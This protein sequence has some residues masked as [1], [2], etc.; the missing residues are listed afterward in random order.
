M[1]QLE[2]S[3]ILKG[4]ARTLEA[5]LQRGETSLD[6]FNAATRRTQSTMKSARDSASVF[7]AGLKEQKRSIDSLRASLDPLYASSKRYE[8]VVE[9]TQRAVASGATTQANANKIMALAEAQYLATGRSAV[10]M[11]RSSNVAAGQLGNITAQFNDIG[12]MLAAGQNPFQLALQQGT[13]LNQVFAQIGGGTKVLRSLGAAFMSMINPVSLM[14]L[15]VIAGGAALIQ[16]GMRALGA[17]E[18]ARTLEERLG[19]LKDATGT[20]R[21]FTDLASAS[22]EE[23]EGK[24][25]SFT[26]TLSPVLEMLQRIAAS[27][28]QSEIDGLASSLT[29]LFGVAGDGDRRIGVASFFDVNIGLAFSK[30][31]KDARGEARLLTS[32]FV[33]Q[34]DALASS[35]GDLEAQI[36]HLSALLSATERLSDLDG[37]RTADEDALLKRMG[38]SLLAMLSQQGAVENAAEAAMAKQNQAYAQ[39]YQSRIKGEEFLSSQR[40]DEVKQL[41]KIYQIYQSTRATSDAAASAGQQKLDELLRQAEIQGVI[42]QYGE[43]SVEAAQARIAAERE[44]FEQT[45]LSADMSQTLRDQIMSAWDAAN[46]LASVDIGAGLSGAVAQ[47]AALADNLGIALNQALSLQNMRATK[48][49]GSGRG[50]GMAEVRARRGETDPTKGRFVYTGPRL[51]A[52][53]NVVTKSRGGGGGTGG[54]VNKA[55]QDRTRAIDS[56][57]KEMDR[58]APSYDRDVAALDK[59]RSETLAALNPAKAGYEEF[60]ADVASIYDEK[61]AEAYQRDLERRD[62]W[63]AGVERAFA[64]VNDDMASWASVGENLVTE[65]SSGFEDAFV[66][67]SKTG[68]LSVGDLVDYTLDQLQRLA[69]QSVIQPGIESG[70]GFLTEMVSGLFGGGGITAVQS[71]AG[72]QIGTGGVRRTYG[73][74]APL[75]ADERLTVTTLGQR[76][77]T[78]EQISNGA[79]VVDTLAAAASTPANSNDA[80]VFSPQINIINQS[81]AQVT[82]EV[83]EESNSSGQRSYALMIA[84]R[85]GTALTT[86][87]GGAKR[88]M[89]STFGVKQRRSLR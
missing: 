61:L 56:I 20:Y 29:D 5:A 8:A 32:E 45:A 2:T 36:S 19:D 63:A 89:A 60:A 55:A 59:W 30:A 65:W 17:G 18:K 44:A 6:G 42:A 77:F 9:E 84:D 86:P 64:K 52:N 80:T 73:P 46:G 50:D 88:T 15:G 31:Q 70:F 48:S 14:T 37:K 3:L 82:G 76:V 72:S 27:T 58:L 54:S 35:T 4:D 85:V 41:S 12:V 24:F 78:P 7:E 67:M 79:T 28:A 39:Y 22:T 47:A 66:E 57:A 40:A 1:S 21:E 51:D 74:G 13:Q 49:Y 38:D 10:T 11:G 62:D 83:K 25:G 75:R 33:S 68:K 87:G 53:N 81:S 43:K 26:S 23:L 69:Y 71:H 16:W 34:R